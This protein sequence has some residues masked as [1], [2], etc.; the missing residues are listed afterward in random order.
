MLSVIITDFRR[1]KIYD[2][3]VTS[4]GIT[5]TPRCVKIYQLVRKFK[6][7][8]QTRRQRIDLIGPRL[9]LSIGSGLKGGFTAE[10]T[11]ASW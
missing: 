1:F 10:P 6:G 7:G 2:F 9:A 4:N 3:G 8:T 5:Y 11:P